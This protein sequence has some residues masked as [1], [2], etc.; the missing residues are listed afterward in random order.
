M[1]PGGSGDV[2]SKRLWYEQRAKKNR[3]GSPVIRDGHVYVL[4]MDGI[5]ECLELATG[6]SIWTERLKGPGAKADSWSSFTMAGDKLYTINQSGDAFEL[7]ASPKF[8]L[9]ATNSIGEYTNSS[10]AHSD[11]ELFL[12]TYES[13]WCIGA[14][15]TSASAK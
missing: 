2:T 12:R 10:F 9:L 14:P 7:R 6:K 1:K 4:N 13:L 11:G 3:I 5:A 15:R 8:E